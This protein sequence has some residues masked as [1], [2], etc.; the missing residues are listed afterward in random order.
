MLSALT[1]SRPDGLL[2]VHESLLKFALL[3]QDTGKVRMSCC[4]LWEHLMEK[5]NHTIC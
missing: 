1:V 2:V 3:L 4:K 5:Q